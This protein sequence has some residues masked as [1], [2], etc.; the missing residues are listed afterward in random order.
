MRKLL[1]GCHKMIVFIFARVFGSF[2]Y[3]KAFFPKGRFFEHWYSKG[4]EWVMPDFWGRFMLKRN[5]KIPWPTSPLATVGKDIV[6]DVD[7]IDNFQSPGTYYQ[8][9]DAKITIG[10]GTNIAQNCG[11][12]TSNH[13]L[14]DL[15]KRGKAEDIVIGENC[16]IGMNSMILPGVHLGNHTIV[17]AGSVVTHSFPDGFCVIAGNPAT[18]IK[19]LNIQE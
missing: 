16:W 1:L 9:W 14:L 18:I 8:T 11:L 19:R 2:M 4:W 17:G 13:D 12:I 7:D 15:Q 3:K 6:F 5:K 10:K